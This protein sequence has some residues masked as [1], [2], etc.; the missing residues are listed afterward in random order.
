MLQIYI[1]GKPAAIK[2]G[3]SFEFVRENPLFSDADD[4]SLDISFPLRGCPEN[5]QIFG[6]IN[7]LA[8]SASPDPL[9]M[10]IIAGASVFE[11]VG[12]ITDVSDAEVKVQFLGQISAQNY[13]TDLDD[14]YIHKLDLGDVPV[15]WRS[16]A[17]VSVAKAAV[18]YDNPIK[19][20]AIPWVNE[21]SGN[22]QNNF[23]SQIVDMMPI[24]QWVNPDPDA[25]ADE[26]F[27]LSWMPFLIELARKIC[28]AIG[29]DCDFEDWLNSKY[30]YLLCC[31][32]VPGVWGHKW[33]SA[34]P[35]WSVVEF[36]RNIE[37]VIEG[38]FFIDSFNMKISFRSYTSMLSNS[39]FVCD[40]IFDEFSSEVFEDS[41]ECKYLPDR[42]IEYNFPD[43]TIF[44][45]YSCPKFFSR[46][47]FS[48]FVEAYDSGG[49]FYNQVYSTIQSQ[50]YFLS[51]YV[52]HKRGVYHIYYLAEENRYIARR[53]IQVKGFYDTPIYWGA[54]QPLNVFG[55][56]NRP[57]NADSSEDADLS[58]SVIP[59][60][61]LETDSFTRYPFINCGSL[62]NDDSSDD[63]DDILI[64]E[65]TKLPVSVGTVAN[66]LI[67]GA[68]TEK[69]SNFSNLQVAFY[70]PG[71]YFAIPNIDYFRIECAKSDVID[72]EWT[73]SLQDADGKFAGLPRVDTS[74][75]F[76]FSFLSDI[77]PDPTSIF[78]FRGRRFLCESLTASA[79][80]SG[81][82][83][84]IKGVFWRIAD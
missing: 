7:H 18:G 49:A 76:Q 46:S 66:E 72:R 23:K 3:S 65:Y 60:K 4:F 43:E 1:N 29:Y 25:K 11:G 33:A 79:D 59:V 54:Y 67:E 61:M 27:Q 48:T 16:S 13:G 70:P 28:D 20:V 15:Q 8:H 80:E 58:L 22:I 34:L 40:D 84:R 19:A 68:E 5:V 74:V 9:D 36:F 41:S 82:S 50:K 45:Y 55:P 44:K 57:S 56:R 32:V 71:G 42:Y 63:F 53:V 12:V 78:I 51:P 21:Y 47:N 37:P 69:S 52:G 14:I 17:N 73:L 31:N 64:D 77:L 81:F 35:G 75:K 10:K 26:P 30:K 62:D 24:F 38:T 6:F 39:E 2:S 83:Q